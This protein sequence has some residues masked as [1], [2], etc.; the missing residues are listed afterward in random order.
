M[1]E[2][3]KPDLNAPRFRKDFSIVLTPALHKNFITENP[4]YSTLSYKDFKNIISTHNELIRNYVI[5]NRDGIE[6][7]EQIGTIFIGT[8]NRK[9]HNNMDFPRSNNLGIIVQNQSWESDHH[10][11][12]IFY[13]NYGT[14]YPFKNHQI[15]GFTPVRQFKRAVAHEYPKSWKKYVVVDP[16]IAISS[17]FTKARNKAI[18]KEKS[19]L[20]LETYDEFEV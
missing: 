1:R 5:D 12:K 4:K 6:L 15:W 17:L 8:C 2:S 14:K 9:K 7:P 10:L 16:W 19:K 18:A 11:A 20:N 3:R 13:S